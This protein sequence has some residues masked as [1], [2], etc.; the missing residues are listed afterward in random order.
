MASDFRS[1]ARNAKRWLGTLSRNTPPEPALEVAEE[2]EE[3]SQVEQPAAP[4]QDSIAVL[5]KKRSQAM[6]KYRDAV[7]EL[8]L[9][10]EASEQDAEDYRKA[11]E[12]L[13]INELSHFDLVAIAGQLKSPIYHGDSFFMRLVERRRM[14]QLGPIPE[15]DFCRN[16]NTD[17]ELAQAFGFRVPQTLWTGQLSEVPTEL[18]HGTFLKPADSAESKGAFYLFGEDD[19][20]SAFTSERLNNW[21]ELLAAGRAQITPADDGQ[22]LNN[23]AELLTVNR[24]NKHSGDADEAPWV[25]QE[26]ITHGDS[27]PARDMKFYMFYGQI[28]LILEVSRYPKVER[29]Y[30]NEDGS[31]AVLG[32]EEYVRFSDP[33]DITAN[34]GGLSAEKLEA[35]RKFSASIPVPFM[36][37]DFLNAEHDLVFCEFSAAPGQSHLLNR[38]YDRTLGKMYSQAMNRLTADLLAG[39]T[40]GTFQEWSARHYPAS[41]VN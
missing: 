37:I 8:R 11:V 22:R 41:T 1:P 24:V 34:Q 35:V 27:E 6:K 29:E 4:V 39:K 13:G 33:S 14:K 15:K 12:R 32:R 31:I 38:K 18:R 20:F 28:G 5:T 25:V 3:V 23:W 36:R 21:D 7:E 17:L 30:L 2:K 16:K 19:I 9:K 10:V 26:M 40:F